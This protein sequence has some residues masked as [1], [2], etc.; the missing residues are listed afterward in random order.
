MI[1]STYF[2]VGIVV[3]PVS[4]ADTLIVVALQ[5]DLCWLIFPLKILVGE[6]I[7]CNDP[8][9]NLQFLVGCSS[10]QATSVAWKHFSAE[11]ISC[12]EAALEHE[13]CRT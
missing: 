12:L 11:Q 2:E 1:E 5:R 3:R 9:R 8:S 6:C 10:P 13:Q 7:V 4:A